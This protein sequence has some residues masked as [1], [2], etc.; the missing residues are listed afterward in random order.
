MLKTVWIILFKNASQQIRYQVVLGAVHANQVANERLLPN[1]SKEGAQE[2]LHVIGAKNNKI[3]FSLVAEWPP[4]NDVKYLEHTIIIYQ[5]QQ[6][7]VHLSFITW[8]FYR[9]LTDRI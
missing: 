2:G 6:A 5:Q 9:S 1:S 7:I 8:S 3:S 4:K